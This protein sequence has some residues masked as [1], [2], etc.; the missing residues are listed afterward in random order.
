M[1]HR[2]LETLPLLTN[3][4]GRRHPYVLKDDVTMRTTAGHDRI[5]ALNPYPRCAQ[6]DEERR[7]PLGTAPGIRH[8]KQH[9]DV[10]IGRT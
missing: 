5:I 6:V 4:V 7:N 10:G 9:G 8:R 2:Q 3:A 1:P